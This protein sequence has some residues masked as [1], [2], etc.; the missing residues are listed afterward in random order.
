MTYKELAEEIMS[1][2]DKEQTHDVIIYSLAEDE[3][4]GLSKIDIS[5]SG[6]YILTIF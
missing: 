6:D 4:Y 1:W 3:H 2:T 5:L